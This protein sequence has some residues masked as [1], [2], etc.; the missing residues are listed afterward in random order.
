MLGRS[1]GKNV[2]WGKLAAA[3]VAQEAFARDLEEVTWT[4]SLVPRAI[5]VFAALSVFRFR[6]SVFGYSPV[7]GERLE[8]IRVSS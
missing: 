1:E 8:R 3:Q 4:G 6:F 5:H 2:G 7:M